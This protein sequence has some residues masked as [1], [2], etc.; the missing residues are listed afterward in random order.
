MDKMSLIECR[1]GKFEGLFKED[2]HQFFG[3]PYAKYEQ[4]WDE[5]ALFEN[6]LDLR[7]LKKG[8]SAPQTRFIDTSKSGASFFQDNSLSEQSEECLTLNICSNDIHAKNPVMVWIHGG[9]LVTGGSSSIMYDL[10]TL[11]KG[12]V[13]VSINYRLGHLVS[14]AREVSGGQIKSSGNEANRSKKCN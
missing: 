8:K 5:S 14:K 6:E 10:K 12:V 4:R 13:V 7:V 2:C 3:I 1:A 9:A 11:A